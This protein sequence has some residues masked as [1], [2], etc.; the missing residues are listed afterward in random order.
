MPVAL[1][2]HVDRSQKC[3]LKG[4]T[5]YVH[6]WDW[7]DND[8]QPG[9]VRLGPHATGPRT[10]RAF[11]VQGINL[12]SSPPESPH[13][14][15]YVKFED[16]EWTLDGTTEPGLYPILP[17]KRTWKLDKNRKPSVLKVDRKQIPLVPA[18]AITAHASQ[19]KTLP[20]GRTA[21]RNQ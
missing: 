5:G 10:G 16:A 14:A 4:R 8:Q 7:K 12:L 19:G 17:T 11:F 1:T 9:V 6:S 20:L 2:H 15:R 18:F 13:A 21:Q 3:L